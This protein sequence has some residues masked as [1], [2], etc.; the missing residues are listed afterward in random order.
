MKSYDIQNQIFFKLQDE[1][2]KNKNALNSVCFNR[3]QEIRF[4]IDQRREELKQKIDEISLEMIDQVK[5]FE[6][7]Y[8]KSFNSNID[9]S[10]K[11]YDDEMNKLI[12]T[13][14]DPNIQIE[15]IKQME[16]E[17]DVSLVKIKSKLNEMTRIKENLKTKNDFKSQF[18]ID[19]NTF[20]L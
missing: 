12:E 11:I 6:A 1:F 8:L 3:F 4:K 17:Q 16:R 7:S 19:V 18:S 5:E 20:G 13:F 9:C 14:R 15:S 2:T 10:L